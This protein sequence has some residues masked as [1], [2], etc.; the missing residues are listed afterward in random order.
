MAAGLEI[1]RGHS[2]WGPSEG[3]Y[4]MSAKLVSDGAALYDGLVASQPPWIYLFGT[5]V[6]LVHDSIDV[7]R[8][9]CGAVTVGAALV[10]SEAV[11]RLTA[12]RLA[13]VVAAPVLLLTPWA[14]HQHGL[15][16]PE[17]LGAPLLL[18]AALTAAR[19]EHARLTGV[20]VG[21]A[22]FVKLPFALPAV[23]V[24]LVAADRRRALP[25][26]LGTVAAQAAAFTAI[27][28]VDFW[29]QIVVAQMQAGDDLDLQAG[30]FAQAAWNLAPLVLLAGVGV[31]FAQSARE[32]ELVKTVAATALGALLLLVTIVKPGTGL[33]VAVPAETLLVPLAV[34]GAT[35]LVRMG[36]V[37]AAG[38]SAAVVFMFA[39]SGSLL[40]APEDPSP[41]HR[42]GSHTAGWAVVLTKDE[43]AA[44]VER[45]QACPPEAAY[46]GPPLAAFIADR[47]VQGDQP[48]AFILQADV[49]DDVRAAQAADQP[50]CE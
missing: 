50:V 2:D 21:L 36:P 28:G 1:A 20:L 10:A 44:A 49:H 43:M 42:V 29:E 41:F 6:L 8:A 11:W 27:F 33:N 7:L 45:A 35:R 31:R 47:R 30:F 23:A 40:V 39:Q 12:S 46:T 34:F 48:D 37:L 25:W 38:A 9:A 5:A 22:P 17:L 26:A 18:A 3:V 16:L 4:A 24:L 19:A 32:P 13:S 15:L 14:L